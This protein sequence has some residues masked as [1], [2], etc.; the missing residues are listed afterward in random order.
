MADH[1]FEPGDLKADG[2]LRPSQLL[3]CARK[4]LQLD[5][6]EQRPERIDIEGCGH[7]KLRT[8]LLDTTPV[9]RAVRMRVINEAIAK[10]NF[11]RAAARAISRARQSRSKA[12]REENETPYCSEGP[13][14]ACRRR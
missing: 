5:D 9:K 13:G 1:G 4:T 11:S 14:T 6:G 7:E 10:I 8:A 3:R 2:G 12:R